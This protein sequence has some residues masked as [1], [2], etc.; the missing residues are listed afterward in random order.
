MEEKAIVIFPSPQLF[1]PDNIPESVGFNIEVK[2]P[3]PELSND[4]YSFPY[5]DRNLMADQILKV[6]LPH[7]GHRKII[8]SCFDAD[9]C[10]L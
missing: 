5:F 7:A 8:F 10:T 2:Y 9:M 1:N 6:V 3:V 4:V